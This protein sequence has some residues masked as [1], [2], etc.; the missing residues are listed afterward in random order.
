MCIRDRILKDA[1]PVTDPDVLSVWKQE[2]ERARFKKPKFKL[3]CSPNT[4]TPLSIGLF[5]RRIR[6]VLPDRSYSREELSLIFRHEIVHIGRQD[7]WSKF[8]LMFCT[9]MCW[10]NPLMWMAMRRSA[11]DWELSCDETVLVGC[12]E[13]ARKQYAGLLLHTA[14]DE[15]GFTT[16]L[17]ATASALRYRLR[18]VVKPAKKRSGAL[19][20]GLVFFV[21]CMSCG[22][23]ALAYDGSTGAEV[24]YQSRDPEE[25][26]VRHMELADDPYDT[27]WLCPDPEAFHAYM[28]SLELYRLT[29]NYSFQGSEREF[30]FLYDAPE[31]TLAVVLCDETLKVVPLYGKALTAQWYYIPGGTDWEE[32]R[33][34]VI[35][36]PAL[37]LSFQGADP[38]SLQK[39]GATLYQLDETRNDQSTRLISP[40]MPLEGEASGVFGYDLNRVVLDFSR[41]LVSDFRVEVESRDGSTCYSLVQSDLK[42]PYTL[43]LADFDARYTGFAALEGENG[44]VYDAVFRFDV[45]G[46]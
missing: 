25:Y 6:V 44:A 30:T 29:G 8:F 39:M 12:D 45:G 15:R 42:D 9:A 37:N 43:P 17:S 11:D 41:P 22:Y 5:Q 3:A 13:S 10:F 46:A 23:T 24:I 32:L 14:G 16:C 20:V 19:L 26:S 2:L 21:L 28:A 4:A 40:E 7:S 36:A 18:N 38:F 33:T 31:G 35:P 27:T 1:E 34:I